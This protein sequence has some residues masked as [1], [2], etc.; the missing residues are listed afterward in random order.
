V[1]TLTPFESVW[2]T[3]TT[4]KTVSV[5]GCV[6][7]DYLVMLAVGDMSSGNAVTAVTTTTTVGSTT[8]WTEPVEVLTQPSNNEDWIST[9]VAQVTADGSVTVSVARTKAGTQGGMWG[10]FVLKATGSSG[11]G[12]VASTPNSS[13]AQVVSLVVSQANSGVAFIMGDWDAGAVGTAWVPATAAVLVE[14]TQVTDYTV[15]ASYWPSEAA[16]TRSYGSSG[17][18]GTH[19]RCAALEIK[20]SGVAAAAPYVP[21]RLGPNYRR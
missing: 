7:G 17:G 3:T 11:V 20:D 13:A 10:F 21:R 2:N 14:R 19:Y 15:Y 12:N 1:P 6:T 9:A 8:A 5:T 4:P 16:G 18:A